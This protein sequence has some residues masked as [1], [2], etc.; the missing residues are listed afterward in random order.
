LR[1]DIFVLNS[2]IRRKSCRC[3][4]QRFLSTL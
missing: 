2:F 4:S 3:L 1:L